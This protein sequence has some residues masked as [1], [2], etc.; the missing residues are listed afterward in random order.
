ML[1]KITLSLAAI[2]LSAA[3][4]LAQKQALPGILPKPT[5]NEA[6]NANM[7]FTMNTGTKIITKFDDKNL[8]FALNELDRLTMEIFG[9][10]FK[11]TTKVEGTGNIIIRQDASIKNEGYKLI[12]PDH[13][14]TSVPADEIAIIEPS[15]NG[16]KISMQ[17]K[18]LKVNKI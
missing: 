2:F 9:M 13:Y 3:V 18:V 6:G 5:K 11:I 10:K 15:G 14:S 4:S 16:Y 1:K 7:K 12:S 17:G 8:K